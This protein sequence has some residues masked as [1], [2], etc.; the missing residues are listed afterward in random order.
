MTKKLDP[1]R[2]YSR[3]RRQQILAMIESSRDSSIS[4]TKSRNPQDIAEMMLKIVEHLF[5]IPR[6]EFLSDSRLR[7]YVVRRTLVVNLISMHTDLRDTG[8]AEIVKKDRTSVIHM[9]KLHNDLMYSDGTYRDYFER[10]SSL[11]ARANY[12]P[13]IEDVTLDGII[14]KIVKLNEE[15]ELLNGMLGNLLVNVKSKDNVTSTE[16]ALTD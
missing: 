2:Q 12:L 13:R 3:K 14:E 6:G 15:V 1:K 4:F 16:Q 8:I 7:D 10:S 11:Y 9:Q 5:H